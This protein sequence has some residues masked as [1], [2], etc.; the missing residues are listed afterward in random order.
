MSAARLTLEEAAEELRTKP[1]WLREWLRA[2]A[3][4]AHIR[5]FDYDWAV[6]ALR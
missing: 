4:T 3:R 5:Y 1:R 6:N 2:H